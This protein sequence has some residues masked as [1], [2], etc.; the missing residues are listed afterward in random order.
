MLCLCVSVCVVQWES[1]LFCLT[2][3][4]LCCGCGCLRCILCRQFSFL[5]SVTCNGQVII[6]VETE[7]RRRMQRLTGIE[8]ERGGGRRRG[9]HKRGRGGHGPGGG[10]GR[11]C[12]ESTT[13]ACQL[14]LVWGGCL[15]CRLGLQPKHQQPQCHW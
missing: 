3:C 9:K 12:L 14:C 4:L 2:D 8:R 15:P 11:G 6:T 13:S 5:Q 7:S 10:E 1:V